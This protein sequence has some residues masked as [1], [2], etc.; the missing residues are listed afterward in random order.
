M[1]GPSPKTEEVGAS[2]FAQIAPSGNSIT[3]GYRS[4][5]SGAVL[6]QITCGHS[7][8]KRAQIYNIIYRRIT[9]PIP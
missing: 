2:N 7:G 9:S 4:K 1:E 5:V 8:S 3:S 6:H